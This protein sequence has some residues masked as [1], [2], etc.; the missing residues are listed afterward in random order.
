MNL[1]AVVEASATL[2]AA[3]STASLASIQLLSPSLWLHYF[4]SP[5]A[6]F[7]T[8]DGAYICGAVYSPSILPTSLLVTLINERG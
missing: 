5:S 1:L 4:L 8:L 2:L 6:V 3:F 7:R